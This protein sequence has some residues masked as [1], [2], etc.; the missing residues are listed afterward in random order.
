MSH[1]E[2]KSSHNERKSSHNEMPNIAHPEGGGGGGGGGAASGA[3]NDGESLPTMIA[4]LHE[5]AAE[6]KGK[7]T[8]IAAGVIEREI[9]KADA[10]E[11]E[12][13]AAE[14]EP[15]AAEATVAK[16]ANLFFNNLRFALFN[17]CLGGEV[18]AETE[19]LHIQSNDKIKLEVAASA[20]LPLIVFLQ[21]LH[22][23]VNRAHAVVFVPHL[24]VIYDNHY[25]D[26]HAY[27]ITK[28]QYS[29][30]ESHWRY[31]PNQYQLYW[32]KIKSVLNICYNV[33][34]TA[35]DKLICS[36][37]TNS[38]Y[39]PNKRQRTMS[40]KQHQTK[41]QD[42]SPGG[43][44][45][46]Y[47]A[48]NI[49]IAL[50]EKKNSGQAIEINKDDIDR[51]IKKCRD[52]EAVKVGFFKYILE[53]QLKTPVPALT[54][55][56]SAQSSLVATAGGTPVLSRTKSSVGGNIKRRKTRRKSLKNKKRVR[57]TKRTRK[58]RSRTKRRKRNYYK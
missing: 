11:S 28:I 52:I 6:T 24:G 2:R 45:C 14:S 25:P 12:A 9:A 16:A 55:A 10:A 57:K 22:N 29:V 43:G 36:Q 48:I 53:P 33:E 23:P 13:D 47:S 54:R 42:I 5:S 21:D 50:M 31:I 34:G 20:E 7:A 44:V 1:N 41:M 15:A 19:V 39:T 38:I 8:G 56:L 49:Y 46:L 17:I 35:L 58:T 3:V 51:L 37:T 32:E 4:M 30:D 27:T 18:N 26:N 40:V